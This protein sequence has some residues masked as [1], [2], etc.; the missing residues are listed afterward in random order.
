MYNVDILYIHTC[1]HMHTHGHCAVITL[2]MSLYQSHTDN[3]ASVSQLSSLSSCRVTA[4]IHQW[5]LINQKCQQHLLLSPPV[6][7]VTS[8]GGGPWSTSVL[9]PEFGHSRL[10]PISASQCQFEL[11]GSYFLIGDYFPKWPL[12]AS[13][14]R[15]ERLMLSNTVKICTDKK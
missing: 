13:G 7:V 12:F 9:S 4:V 5:R 15:E 14:A 3:V 6:T 11:V 10:M 8:R 2:N 1:T